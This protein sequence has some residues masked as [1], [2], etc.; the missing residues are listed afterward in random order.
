MN[1]G[2]QREWFYRVD[3]SS[4]ISIKPTDIRIGEISMLYYE[5]VDTK[6]PHI[7]IDKPAYSTSVDSSA[8]SY[9]K[10]VLIPAEVVDLINAWIESPGF[11]GHNTIK[12]MLNSIYA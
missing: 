9:G 2:T 7:V 6:A 5:I 4:M 11:G 1:D 3:A 8:Y 10:H 12:E